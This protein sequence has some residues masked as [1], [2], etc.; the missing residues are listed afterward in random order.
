MTA[1][2]S[3]EM[4]AALGE[5]VDDLE[6]AEPH[7]KGMALQPENAR[8]KVDDEQL[9]LE[10]VLGVASAKVRDRTSPRDEVRDLEVAELH[11]KGM[12]LQPE[13]EPRRVDDEQLELE[14]DL[15]VPSAKVRD[16]TSLDGYAAD[17]RVDEP[18]SKEPADEP[19]VE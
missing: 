3:V 8:R 15:G 18:S 6:V 2:T 11:G 17:P 13:N 16:R 19:P 5:I 4:M 12:A 9:E 7:E 10:D 1:R 14:D